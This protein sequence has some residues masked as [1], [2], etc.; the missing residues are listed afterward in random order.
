MS[1]LQPK[2]LFKAPNGYYWLIKQNLIGF[3]P[4]TILQPWYYVD[5]E[6]FFSLKNKWPNGPSENELVAFAK[7]QDNDYLSCFEISNNNV[8]KILLVNG[9]TENGYDILKSYS[10]FWEWL[11]GVID[12]V[13]EWSELTE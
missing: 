6:N 3:E 10:N 1:S 12:D 7:R 13:A 8:I 5:N 2:F 4:F 9:W 11:K